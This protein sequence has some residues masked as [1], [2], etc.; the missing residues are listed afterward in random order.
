MRK[1]FFQNTLRTA[2]FSRSLTH[3]SSFPYSESVNEIERR[4]NLKKAN[5]V[6]IKVGSS[7]VINPNGHLSLSKMGGLVEQLRIL[8]QQGREVL[9]V[10]SGAVG[11]GRCILGMEKNVISDPANVIDR[12]ACA[13]TGQEMLMSTYYSMFS[14]LGMECAQVLLTQQD[15]SS[16]QRYTYLADTIEKIMKKGMIPVINENDVVT[17]CQ[18][19][20]KERCFSDNDMLSA[21]VAA[22]VQANAVAIMT[23]VDGVYTRPP[24]TQGAKRISLFSQD[25]DVNIGKKS[26][27]GRGGMA[28][29]INAAK[30]AADGGAC[31]IIANGSN[32]ANVSKIFNGEPVGT[33]FPSV[34]APP[35]RIHHWLAY[36]ATCTG[37]L[38][39]KSSALAKLENTKQE[40]L[41]IDDILGVNGMFGASSAVSLVSEGGERELARGLVQCGA[42]EIEM[43]LGKHLYDL[44]VMKS[45]DMVVRAQ[46]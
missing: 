42:T 18:E 14:A 3:L 13:A 12:Q 24:E 29:K 7:V 8:R 2:G 36:A 20:D 10:S 37:K 27:Y 41:F 32:I 33:L 26:S 39:V 6:V 40:G 23:D 15:F 11:L 9:L 25:C 5:R 28:S 1:I 35:S 31:A 34:N 30:T 46:L 17:G 38:R 22:G 21:L 44:A 4:E 43:Q 45:S 16:P 19:L